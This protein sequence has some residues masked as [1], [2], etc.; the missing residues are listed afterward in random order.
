M[1]G[2]NI[3]GRIR[4]IINEL[5]NSEKKIGELILKIPSEAI[6]MTAL[7]LATRAGTS[8]ATV[9][10]FCKSIDIPSFTQL[11]VKLSSEIESPTF[12]GYFDI[13]ANEP[14]H[15]IK[16]KLLG[17]AYQSMKETIEQLNDQRIDEVVDVL[18]HASIIYVYGIGASHL[19]AENI[20]QKW[21]R[22]GK[23]TICATDPHILISILVTAPKEAIFI[24]ISNSGET[25]EVI[26]LVEIAKSYKIRTIGLTQFGANSIAG[27]VDY[28]IQT[29]RS[30]EAEL[31]SAAT[32]S[33][34]AQFIAVDALF[35][36]YASRQYDPSIS[37][38]RNSKEEIKKYM[39]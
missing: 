11:K 39:R 36:T 32:S 8:P 27:K 37:M 28:S 7:E 23:P 10:R 13:K 26:R 33:L 22:I 34:H 19:V 9:I 38:I 16:A 15:E 30:K 12:E 2:E 18:L 14:V 5:S 35:Y 20:S 3:Q 25:K 29:V 1:I 17:N 24:G 31:R 4:S 6:N 21:N